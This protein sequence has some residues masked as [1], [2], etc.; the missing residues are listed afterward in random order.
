MTSPLTCSGAA[1][2]GPMLSLYLIS[3]AFGGVLVVSSLVFGGGLADADTSADGLLDADLGGDADADAPTD[4]V[5]GQDPTSLDK[6]GADWLWLPIFSL[7]FWSF[8]SAAFGATGSTL[9]SLGV[10]ALL[11]LPAA[12]LAGLLVGSG[13]AWLFRAIR[14]D[15]VS[16]DV[17][18]DRFV[19]STARVS[20][21]IRPGGLGKIVIDA[22]SGDVVMMARTHD[23]ATLPPGSIVLVASIREGTADV[24]RLPSGSVDP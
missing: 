14:V 16:G 18:L 9:S 10:S 22:P 13:A 19:G 7:R 8:G 12:L 20:L 11:H 4:L 5:E 3:L 23:G 6:A 1:L 15:R 17:T 24:T 21:P 2:G